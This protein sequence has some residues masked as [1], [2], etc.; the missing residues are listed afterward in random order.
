VTTQKPRGVVLDVDGTLVDTNY[1]HIVAWW[2]AFRAGGHHVSCATIHEYVGVASDKLIP[3]VIGEMDERVQKAH[4]HY[5]A[6][7][8]EQLLRFPRADEF[9]KSLADAGLRVVLASSA[10][11]E[12]M[13]GL[14]E[15]IGAGEAVHTVVGSADVEGSKPSPEPVQVAMGKAGL[16]PTDCVMVGDT[17]WDIE[18]SARAGV[19]AIGVLSGGISEARL[20]DAGAVAVYRDVAHLLEDL[21]TSPICEL[22]RD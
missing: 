22:L 17:A 19:P 5:Y 2:H 9:V 11:A 4:T 8:L 12:E 13:E 7:F 15:A 6:P 10:S 18:A 21:D 16:E 14:L 3:A 1:Q 20:R